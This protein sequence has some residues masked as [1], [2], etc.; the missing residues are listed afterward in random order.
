ME[1]F[2]PASYYHYTLHYDLQLECSVRSAVA[3]I[4]AYIMSTCLYRRLGVAHMCLQ[5]R[6]FIINAA[7]RRSHASQGDTERPRNPDP[8]RTLGARDRWKRSRRNQ[9]PTV[10]AFETRDEIGK[11]GRTDTSM[12]LCT[13]LVYGGGPPRALFDRRPVM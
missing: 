13:A 1:S 4:V 7:T 6:P 5:R 8:A 3:L 10:S 11:N 2:I 12:A 9:K